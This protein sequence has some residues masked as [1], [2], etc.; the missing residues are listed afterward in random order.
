M[1]VDR[2]SIHAGFMEFV[3]RCLYTCIAQRCGDAI[4]ADRRARRNG[5][6]RISKRAL[7]AAAK[8]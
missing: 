6:R 3:K 1:Q 7:Q 5:R 4:L 8:G 2:Q